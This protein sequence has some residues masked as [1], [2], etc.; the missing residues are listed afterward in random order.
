MRVRNVNKNKRG[1]SYMF[2][3]EDKSKVIV[4]YFTGAEVEAIKDLEVYLIGKGSVPLIDAFESGEVVPDRFN[5]YFR[6]A[7]NDIERKQKYCEV[8]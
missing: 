7:K 8:L 3:K 2:D 1:E 6:Q 5:N 4:A